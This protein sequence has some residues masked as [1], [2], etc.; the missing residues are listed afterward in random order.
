M[1][2]LDLEFVFLFPQTTFIVTLLHIVNYLQWQQINRKI[3]QVKGKKAALKSSLKKKNPKS[4]YP[5][6]KLANKQTYHYRLLLLR[7]LYL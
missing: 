1:K 3:I 7:M 6:L 2:L 4:L 5:S